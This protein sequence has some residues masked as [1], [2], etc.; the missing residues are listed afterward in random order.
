MSEKKNQGGRREGAGRPKVTAKRKMRALRFFDGEW[1]T[2]QKKAEARNISP[3]EYLYSLV[4]HD[5]EGK[6]LN[7]QEGKAAIPNGTSITFTLQQELADHLPKDTA[8]LEVFVNKA[9]EY[10]LN[11]TKIAQIRGKIK[12]P[13]RAAASRENGKKGGRPKKDKEPTI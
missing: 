12:S 10:K 1:D 7:P 2:I 5:T 8:E 3:R 6:G 11:I 4:E 9:L 13:A